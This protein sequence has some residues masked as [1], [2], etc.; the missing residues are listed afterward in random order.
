MSKTESS[1]DSEQFEEG[2]KCS[3]SISG[4]YIYRGNRISRNVG[5]REISWDGTQVIRIIRYDSKKFN[6]PL[7]FY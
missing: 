1:I 5:H 7:H 6:Q 3:G 2:E 4:L